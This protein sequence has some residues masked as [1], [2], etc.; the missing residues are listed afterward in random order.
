MKRFQKLSNYLFI[1]VFLEMGWEKCMCK[2]CT[3]IGLVIWLPSACTLP[4]FYPTNRINFS[5]FGWVKSVKHDRRDKDLNLDP[6]ISNLLITEWAIWPWHEN[7]LD[8]LN[9]L[10]FN[11]LY[12]LFIISGAQDKKLEGHVICWNLKG[13]RSW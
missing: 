2:L 3:A 13:K 7:Q 11:M 4:S 8:L 5:Q 10:Q 9:F 12:I 1:R 6:W